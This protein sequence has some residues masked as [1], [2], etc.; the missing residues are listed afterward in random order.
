MSNTGISVSAELIASI[1]GALL[2]ML[3]AVAKLID[4]IRT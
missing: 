4:L 1:V 3:E 2:A